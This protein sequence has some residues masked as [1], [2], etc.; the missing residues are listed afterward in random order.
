MGGLGGPQ[1]GNSE[2]G[3]NSTRTG[4]GGQ[5]RPRKAKQGHERRQVGDLEAG[6]AIGNT[7]ERG[8][9]A[10]VAC[11]LGVGLLGLRAPL[12]VTPRISLVISAAGYIMHAKFVPVIRSAPLTLMRPRILCCM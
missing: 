7:P 4:W 5:G 9:L 6:Q 1:I 3:K 11:H 12:S 10:A 8:N 2:A